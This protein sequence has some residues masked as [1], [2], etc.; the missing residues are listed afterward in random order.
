MYVKFRTHFDTVKIY[1]ML[2]ALLKVPFPFFAL[3]FVP[4][5]RSKIEYVLY[6]F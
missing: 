4:F 5:S 6:I 3:N 1:L 2:L